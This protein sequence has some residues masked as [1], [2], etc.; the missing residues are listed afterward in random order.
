MGFS[1]S[2]IIPLDYPN[3][4]AR[5][6][7]FPDAYFDACVADQVLEHIES[8]PYEMFSEVSRIVRPDGLFINAT[9][10]TYPVHFGPKDMWRFTPDGH[11]LL[12][13]ES[14]FQV[15]ASGSWG[16]AE[17]LLLITLGLANL[18]VP[19]WSHHPIRRIAEN[20]GEKW[21]IVIWAVGKKL[22][23]FETQNNARKLNK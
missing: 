20:T 23:C 18:S 19:R 1:D 10:M 14:G 6:L 3:Y 22:K 13:E 11:Q 16:G 7:P 5:S 12:F 2:Q 17:A 8:N 21:P 4:D 15:I 9:I